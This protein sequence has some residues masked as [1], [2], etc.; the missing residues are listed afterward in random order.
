DE[1]RWLAETG[2]DVVRH[3]VSNDD[4]V[5]PTAP[6]RLVKAADG[7]WSIAARRRLLQ[8]LDEHRPDVV[9][10]HNLFPA[11]T[12]SV[13]SAAARRGIAVVW[14][15]HNRRVRCVGGGNFRG[16]APCHSCRPGWRVP[17]VLHRC[18]AR[19]APASA[20]VTASSSLF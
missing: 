1:A 9:H 10:V 5:S 3:E 11:L 8:V 4:L 2:V 17:G 13:P 12:G 19:S 6:G 15:V 18:Y 20:L 14:T 7:V 16:D